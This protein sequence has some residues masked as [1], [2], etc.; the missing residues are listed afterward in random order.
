MTLQVT[1]QG[2][3]ERRQRDDALALHFVF[4]AQAAPAEIHILPPQAGKFFSARAG[5]QQGLQLRGLNRALLAHLG[6]PRCQ[7]LALHA[8]ISRLQFRHRL[9]EPPPQEAPTLVAS[10]IRIHDRE[11]RRIA[12][13]SPAREAGHDG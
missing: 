12:V 3:N 5:Q 9:R 2:F 11:A 10:G 13:R 1:Q 7:L 4:D 6:K 8:T